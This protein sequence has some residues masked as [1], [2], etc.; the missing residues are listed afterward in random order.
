[1]VL[2]AQGDH[3][4]D[5]ALVHR[6]HPL[7][8]LVVGI[9]DFVAGVVVVGDGHGIAACLPGGGVRR[10]LGR[11][12]GRAAAAGQLQSQGQ[13]RKGC[14]KAGAFHTFML[15]SPAGPLPRCKKKAPSSPCEKGT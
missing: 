7:R 9:G 10:G 13:G 6:H 14:Q 5:G 15:L 8:G 11:A 3:G 12:G 4:L 2:Q 1:M